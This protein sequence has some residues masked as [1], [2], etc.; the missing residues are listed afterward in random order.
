MPDWVRQNPRD[1]IAQIDTFVAAL[2]NVDGLAA[3]GLTAPQ[4]VTLLSLRDELLTLCDETD[5]AL[6][7][8]RGKVDARDAKQ[9][10]VEANLRSM[11]MSATANI[12]MTDELRAAATL[13]VQDTEPSPGI[14]TVVDDLAVVG[15]PN[16]NN[17]LDWSAPAGSTG[18]IWE[19]EMSM[20]SSGAWNVVGATSK[21]RYLHEEA[22]AGVHR[23]YRIVGRRGDIRG[24]PG[25][26][27]AVYGS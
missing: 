14:I 3:S 26:E 11:G 7:I 1:L 15:H 9:E 8:Y 12:G 27:A 6:G 13:T 22:G 10:T 23:L 21:T 19:V 24:E 25:N 20:G 4:F 18:L 16:G 17:A 5:V 2:N